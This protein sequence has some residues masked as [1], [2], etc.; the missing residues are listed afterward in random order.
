MAATDQTAQLQQLRFE[1]KQWEHAFAA[2]HGGQ[3]AS[4]DD[5]KQDAE[6]GM[7]TLCLLAH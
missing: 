4:K 7:S 2:D 1:L 5:I 6:I 3:K